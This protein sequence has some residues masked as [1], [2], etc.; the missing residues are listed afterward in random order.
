MK[1]VEISVLCVYNQLHEK[2][3][4]VDDWAEWV[5]VDKDGEVWGFEGKPKTVSSF[6]VYPSFNQS[7]IGDMEVKGNGCEFSDWKEY[8]FRVEDV[9][10]D[11]EPEPEPEPIPV[12]PYIDPESGR[13]LKI[14]WIKDARHAI[15]ASL[16]TCKWIVDCAITAGRRGTHDDFVE[17]LR[18]YREGVLAG[19]IHG[20]MTCNSD[21]LTDARR[22]ITEGYE[23][24]NLITFTANFWADKE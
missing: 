21:P 2:E 12:G 22:A 6:W 19:K 16:A 18:F 17:T 8:A 11:P 23:V 10:V 15:G 1:K 14:F 7:Q 24:D 4:E 5:A 3:F 13:T 9:L 20:D